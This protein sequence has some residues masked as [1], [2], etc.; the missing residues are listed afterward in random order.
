[1]RERGQGENDGWLLLF[2]VCIPQGGH[3]RGTKNCHVED[4]ETWEKQTAFGGLFLWM[5]TGKAEKK[6]FQNHLA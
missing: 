1:M 6:G 4:E 5:P 3:S 2:R